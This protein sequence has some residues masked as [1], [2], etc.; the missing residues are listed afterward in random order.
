MYDRKGKVGK[1]NTNDLLIKYESLVKKQAHMMKARLPPSVEVDDLIQAGMMGLLD[2][3]GRYEE[4]HGAQFET[5]ATQRIRGAMIDELRANDWLPRGLRQS[6]RKIEDAIH[7]LE[8]ELGRSPSESEVA[9]KLK[10]SIEEYQDMLSDGAGH[11]LIYYEDF[12]D[13]DS[14]EH[15]LDRYT[16]DVAE[17]PLQML[18]NIQFK[19]DLVDAIKSLPEREQQLM[20]M[21]YDHEMNL[22]EIGAVMNV[23]ESRV[24][25]LHSQ[26]ISRLR[27]RL[28][29]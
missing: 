25:Q 28:R 27:A 10:I 21:Y 17:D 22:K 16:D 13:P 7:K 8:H 12:L 5:Y 11:Q 2:A 18:L 20:A 6:M 24:S 4:K 14:N 26:A 29:S 15:F 1:D 19:Q 9:E 3:I 23:T